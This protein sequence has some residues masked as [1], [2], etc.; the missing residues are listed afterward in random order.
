VVISAQTLQERFQWLMADDKQCVM[1]DRNQS[2]SY[3][4]IN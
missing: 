1:C 4:S 3:Q 2:A